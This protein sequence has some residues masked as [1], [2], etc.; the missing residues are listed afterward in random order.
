[1]GSEMCIRDRTLIVNR[2][3]DRIEIPTKDVQEKDRFNVMVGEII[4]V[5][6]E[7]VEGE[8]TVDES[9]L[10]GESI[11]LTKEKGDQVVGGSINLQGNIEI[12]VKN[13]IKNQLI[14]LSKT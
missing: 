11:P 13:L 9:L 5:D 10:T 12:E 1:M 6:G 2:D 14:T 4:P 3:E 8:T 7:I